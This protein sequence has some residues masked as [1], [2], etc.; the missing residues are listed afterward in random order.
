MNAA[1][2]STPALQY[3]C[4]TFPAGLALLIAQGPKKKP[5]EDKVREEGEE[6]ALAQGDTEP[7]EKGEEA[8]SLKDLDSSDHEDASDPETQL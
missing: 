8:G 6:T 7:Q 1:L 4:A 2:T 3:Y 5:V